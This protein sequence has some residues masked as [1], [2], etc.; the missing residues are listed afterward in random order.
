MTRLTRSARLASPDVHP[1]GR[2]IA[3]VQY[4]GDR[5]RLVTVAFGSGNITPLTE[6]STAIAWGPARWSPDGM[7]LAAVRFTRG[8]SFDLVLLS[9]D[10]R[11]LQSL[12]DDRALEGIPDWDPSVPAGIRRL[13]FTSDRTGVRELYALELEGDA[14]PRLYVTARVATGIHEVAVV[15]TQQGSSQTNGPGALSGRTTIVAVVTHADGR[16]LER[17]EIDRAAWIAAPAPSAEYAQLPGDPDASLALGDP[18]ETKPYAPARDLWPTGWSPVFETVEELGLFAGAATGGVDVIGRHAWQGNVAYGSDGRL[19]GSA[20]YL[21]R[22]FR[23]AQLFGQVA[24]TW[25]LEQQIESEAGELLRLERKRS[26]AVGV[27]FPWQTFRRTTLFSASVAIEDRHR[28]NGGDTTAVSIADPIQ[29]DPTLV[30]GGLGL[31]FGNTQAGLRSISVQDGVRMSAFIDY[32]EATSGDRWRSGWNVAASVYRSFPSWTTAG[33][34]V[35]AATARIAEQRGPAASRL[36]AGGVGTTAVL[37][38]GDSD[39]EV[40]GYPP[41]FVA[42][43]ALWSART[44]MRLPIAR[45]SRGLGALPLYLRGL[46]GSWFIDSVGAAIRVDRLGSPQLLSTGAELSS[47]IT[48]FSFLPIRIRTGVGVPLKGLGPVSRGD[49]RFYLTAGTSF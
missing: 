39:F 32:L 25:R 31:S 4:D 6:F 7:R 44:E 37:D 41:G 12:T 13:F 48:L 34:P 22:R 40:R 10:G 45:V 38:G 23:R 24:S 28:E 30:G 29:Q 15:P 49:A 33:R 17:F 42:A 14:D 19:I 9:A 26:A 11:V 46:S 21:Y 43:S 2:T 8:T 47:D 27:A 5:S 36:T 16:H 35:F 18:T 3:A 20:S 1:T